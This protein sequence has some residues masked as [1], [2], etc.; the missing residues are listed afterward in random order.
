MHY[1]DFKGRVTKS[2]LKNCQLV[3]WDHNT[4]QLGSDLVFL[5]GKR[6]HEEF[7]MDFSYPLNMVQALGIGEYLVSKL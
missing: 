5:F 4:D 7:A 2:S 6:G 1:L 3:H